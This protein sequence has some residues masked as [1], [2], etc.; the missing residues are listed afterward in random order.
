MNSAI[1]FQFD[2]AT[3]KANAQMKVLRT[4][5]EVIVKNDLTKPYTRLY[6]SIVYM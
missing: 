5:R 6:V 2:A 3:L 1:E 4:A